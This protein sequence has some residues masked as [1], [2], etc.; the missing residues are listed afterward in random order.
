[1]AVVARLEAAAE[2][3][4]HAAVAEGAPARR[5]HWKSKYSSVVSSLIGP[6]FTGPFFRYHD[7][8]CGKNSQ[9]EAREAAK[10]YECG[11]PK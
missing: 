8:N 9:Y 2:A 7:P 6:V 11:L 1:M 3:A 5:S 10:F 4:H